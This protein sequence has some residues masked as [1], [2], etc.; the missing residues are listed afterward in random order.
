[1]E[2]S[3]RD[4]EIKT[5]GTSLDNLL[6][7][8]S[9]FGGGNNRELKKQTVKDKLKWFFNEF[10]GVG[11]MFTAKKQDDFDYNDSMFSCSS[12]MMA[13]SGIK[14]GEDSNERRDNQDEVK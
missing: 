1:M 12:L 7:P 10:F 3:F 11:S 13:D 6:P 2:S 5:I 4:G 14:Y 8:M 9:R